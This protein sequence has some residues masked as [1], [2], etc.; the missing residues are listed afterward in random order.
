MCNQAPGHLCT[1]CCSACREPLRTLPCDH[2][3]HQHTSEVQLPAPL[4]FSITSLCR[5]PFGQLQ[6]L[7]RWSPSCRLG[8]SLQLHPSRGFRQ[9]KRF[10]ASLQDHWYVDMERNRG[11]RTSEAIEYAG[12]MYER[13]CRW[14]WEPRRNMHRHDAFMMA[15]A[16]MNASHLVHILAF[17]L[18]LKVK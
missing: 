14:P 12:D 5:R 3:V 4:G 16:G 18:S 10:E 13:G 11:I 17:K 6:L 9:G 2:L 8:S 15:R 7:S 1:A